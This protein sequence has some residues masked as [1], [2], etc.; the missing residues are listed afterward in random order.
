MRQAKCI[1]NGEKKDDGQ[2]VAENLAKS[3]S[4]FSIEKLSQI[5]R[6]GFIGDIYPSVT[7]TAPI[8]T[9]INFAKFLFTFPFKLAHV[10]SVVHLLVPSPTTCVRMRV[11]FPLTL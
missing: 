8:F 4:K 5:S 2:S 6:A 7:K 9:K 3:K 10:R 11:K 1:R